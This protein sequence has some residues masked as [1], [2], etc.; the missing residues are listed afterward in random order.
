[1]L[2]NFIKGTLASIV[3]C[4]SVWQV[5]AAEVIKLA[6]TANISHVHHEAA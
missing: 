4:A 1:M 2:S 3:F 6:H 5:Q